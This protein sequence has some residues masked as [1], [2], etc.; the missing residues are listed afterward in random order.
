MLMLTYIVSTALCSSIS[1]VDHNQRI[2]E[3]LKISVSDISRNCLCDVYRI[4]DV[5][6]HDDGVNQMLVMLVPAR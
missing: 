2:R 1:G 6:S 4:D 5:F 3:I